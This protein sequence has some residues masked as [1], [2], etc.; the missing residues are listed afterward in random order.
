MTNSSEIVF[1]VLRSLWDLTPEDPRH[2]LLPLDRESLEG[3]LPR[4]REFVSA[5]PSQMKGSVDHDALVRGEIVSMGEGSVIEAGA[6]IDRSCRLILGARSVV[7][8]G[9]VL[10]HEVVVGDD[11]LIGAHCEVVRSVIL[12][13]N[14]YLGHF[15][16]M[17]DSIGGRDIIIAGNVMMAN[18]LVEKTVVAL[19][20]R[21]ARL[22]T[23]RTN[24]GALIG[25]GVRFG[26]SSTLSPGCIVLPGMMLPPHVALY[27]T[28]DSRR[29]RT[30]IRDF[31]RTW[32]DKCA[33]NHQG[34]C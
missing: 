20:Y 15:I 33:R 10:R 27:G 31:G 11:C 4:L 1:N 26:A 14:S 18:T 3:F 21:D 34:S 9:A 29:R 7:R 17:G 2:R 22:N 30:L 12:G 24:L 19:R 16:Y 6:V 28:I 13:P 5:A 25:D 8:A 23:N 32:G